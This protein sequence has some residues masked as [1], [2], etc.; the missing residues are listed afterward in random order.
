MAKVKMLKEPIPTDLSKS[1]N[2][3]TLIGVGVLRV[4]NNISNQVTILTM[5]TSS[6]N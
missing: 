3:E 4:L 2:T 6:L 5:K 1:T